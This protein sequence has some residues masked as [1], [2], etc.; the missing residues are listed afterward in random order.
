MDPQVRLVADLPRNLKLTYSTLHRI[1]SVNYLVAVAFSVVEVARPAHARPRISY[2]AYLS[3]SKTSTRARFPSLL[4]QEMSSARN[5][6]VK[7][8][9]KAQSS[10]ATSVADAVCAS[11]SVKWAR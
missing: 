9:R 3:R 7:A 10:L 4:S 6:P 2:T 11:W 5:V 8:E 1:S